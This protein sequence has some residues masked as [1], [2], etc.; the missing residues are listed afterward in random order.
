M[1]VLP[2]ILIGLLAAGAVQAAEVASGVVA[3]DQGAAVFVTSKARRLE[4]REIPTGALRWSSAEAVRPLAAAAGRVLAQAGA[5]AGGLALVILD[6][7]SG[8][9]VGA[10]TLAL[11]EGVSA[12]ID[13]VLGTKF[14]LRMEQAGPQVRL[15][16]TFEQRPVRGAL[17]EDDDEEV[18]REAGAILVDLVAVR[19]TAAAPSP[20]AQGPAPLPAAVAAEADAGAF[21]QRPLRVGARL[22]AVQKTAGG[23]LILRR[24]TET[25]VSLPDTPLPSGVTL[26]AGSADGRHVLL[27][28]PVPGASTD[29]AHAWTVV[30]LDSGLP[31]ASFAAPTATAPFAVAAGR[32]LAVRPARGYRGA[33]GWIE[34]PRRLEAVDALTGA[35]AWKQPIRDMAYSGPYAP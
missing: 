8:R 17:L 29:R 25:G 28:S 13:E 22:V 30:S 33:A 23:G 19:F 20:P 2:A 31:V 12:P 9:R 6:V 35:L 14:D 10:Q 1:R 18:R 24:W 26:Q 3:E 11:P 7:L 4:A 27:S 34:E 5:P 32:V 15:D 21:Q 16:W